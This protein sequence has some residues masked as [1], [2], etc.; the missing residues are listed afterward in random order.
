MGAYMIIQA[1]SHE[2]AA[3]MFIHHPHFNIFP[4]DGVQI[5][6]LLNHHKK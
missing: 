4:G 1:D 3:A 5:I 6:E 2:A